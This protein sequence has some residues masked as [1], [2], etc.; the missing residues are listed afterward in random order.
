[1]TSDTPRT[2]LLGIDPALAAKVSTLRTSSAYRTSITAVPALAFGNTLLRLSLVVSFPYCSV[3]TLLAIPATQRLQG[4]SLSAIQ[5]P[6]TAVMAQRVTSVIIPSPA[7][8]LTF[9]KLP[10]VR[11][12]KPFLAAWLTQSRAGF[13]FFKVSADLAFKIPSLDVLRLAV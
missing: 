7:A 10:L 13:H 12:P 1:M 11:K 6:R 4:F 8:L 2:T 3:M 5:A 9:V